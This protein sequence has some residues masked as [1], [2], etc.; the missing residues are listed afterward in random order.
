MG[1]VARSPRGECV[2]PGLAGPDPFLNPTWVGGRFLLT[3]QANKAG[4]RRPCRAPQNKSE[5]GKTRRAGPP[6]F[7]PIPR[8]LQ[9]GAPTG[10]MR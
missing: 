10:S 5:P 8:R 1:K 3:A 2:K 6:Y 4:F 9:P 7:A